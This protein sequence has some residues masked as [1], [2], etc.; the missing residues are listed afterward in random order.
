MNSQAIDF[1]QANSTSFKLSLRETSLSSSQNTDG[2]RH[3][4][5]PLSHQWPLLTCCIGLVACKLHGGWGVG[6]E[7][8]MLFLLQ[9]PEG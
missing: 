6:A 7:P 5:F 3:N 4:S 1:D 2:Y 8:L 9:L